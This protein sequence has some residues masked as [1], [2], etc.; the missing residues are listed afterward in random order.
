MSKV[1]AC[2]KNEAWVE[3]VEV[4][5]A[6]RPVGAAVEPPP[7]GRWLGLGRLYL[8]CVKRAER[9]GTMRGAARM[10]VV[11]EKTAKESSN[12]K[13]AFRPREEA[14]VASLTGR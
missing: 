12:R 4:P 6:G 8:S 10:M 5:R 9:R 2:V 3:Y 1:G 14:A 13:T 7:S 11:A